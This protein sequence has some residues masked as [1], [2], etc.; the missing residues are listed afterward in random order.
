MQGT[1]V[2]MFKESEAPSGLGNNC[3][4]EKVLTYQKGLELLEE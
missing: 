3:E 2:D 1:H 4:F